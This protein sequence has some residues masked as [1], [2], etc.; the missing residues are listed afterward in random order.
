[1]RQINFQRVFITASIIG[2]LLSYTI[3][4]ALILTD[5]IKRTASD[6]IHFYAA[7]TI[8]HERGLAQIYKI[9]LQQEVEQR[10]FNFKLA[11]KQVLLYNHLPYLVPFIPA[12][13]KNYSLAFFY[14][15]LILLIINL[16]SIRIL[17]EIIPEPGRSNKL[18]LVA[19]ALLFLPIYANIVNG[20]DT[21]FMLMGAA[22]FTWGMLN[23]REFLAGLALSLLTLRPQLALF[24]IIPLFFWSRKALGAYFIASGGL[25]FAS[26]M[27][28]GWQGTLDFIHLLEISASGDWFGMN[29]NAMYNLLGLIIRL[30]PGLS[31]FAI[32]QTAWGIYAAGGLGA[33][34]FFWRSHIKPDIKFAMLVV[35]ALLLEPHLFYHDLSL[36]L[37]PIFILLRES[38]I[39]K[40]LNLKTILLLP[41]AIGFL[42]FLSNANEFLH[43]SSAYV[44]MAAIVGGLLWLTAKAR[45]EPLF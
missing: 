33:G 5:P 15:M 13:I 18:I 29:Q 36:L 45:I 12:F 23:K 39:Q 7:G 26:F 20:Q 32:R 35:T 16:A 10:Q 24:V 11:N 6:F 1:M 19:G 25:A 21:A 31:L 34:V 42:L 41:T 22:I 43:Y 14:W 9:D 37:I 2:I 27:M 3:Q 40:A 30:F 44:L 28:I 4:A 38:R 8:F 17:A